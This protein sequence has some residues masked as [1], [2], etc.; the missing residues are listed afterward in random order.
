VKAL[1]KKSVLI[2]DDDRTI[3][4][5]LK[6]I[7]LMKGF[8]VETAETGREAIEKSKRRFFNLMLLDIKLPD[9]EGTK[10][11]Q[12]VEDTVPKMVK[13]MVTGY[14]TLENAVEALNLGADA[15][16]MKPID[17]Q[18]ML[19]VVEEKLKEQEK[20]EAFDAEKVKVW[21]KTR[22]Q[23]LKMEESEN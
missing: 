20:E 3:L 15:Y 10:L 5:S 14:P 12:E 18:K 2:V 1:N 8:E 22:I 4:E 7:F 17:P 21:I 16:L 23:K 13:I 11:L 6:E 9:M 19:Q